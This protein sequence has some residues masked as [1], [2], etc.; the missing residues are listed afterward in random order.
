MDR[1]W[2]PTLTVLY[3]GLPLLECISVLRFISR[4]CSASYEARWWWSQSTM[5]RQSIERLQRLDAELAGAFEKREDRRDCM[6]TYARYL[7]SMLAAVMGTSTNAADLKLVLRTLVS[8]LGASHTATAMLETPEIAEYALV[9]RRALSLA[10]IRSARAGPGLGSFY[11]GGRSA[12]LHGPYFRRIP[13]QGFTFTAW[14]YPEKLAR[15]DE[16]Q[17][18]LAVRS[19]GAL[20][21]APS[22]GSGSYQRPATAMS[23]LLGDNRDLDAAPG[24]LLHLVA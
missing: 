23:M 8:G 17:H 11:F 21:S 4:W 22:P 24:T 16:P 14:I 9:V 12:A 10:L 15:S 7:S 1:D 6:A 2:L 5:V 20:S 18:L 3:S 19:F 13:E